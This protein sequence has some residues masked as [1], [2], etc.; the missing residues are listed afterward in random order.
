MRSRDD[1]IEDVAL[2]SLSSA[3]RPQQTMVASHDYATWLAATS[4][5]LYTTVELFEASVTASSSLSLIS[6]RE[7]FK[8]GYTAPAK[9]ATQ[10]DSKGGL[11]LLFRVRFAIAFVGE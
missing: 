2:L 8:R 6:L 1:S 10:G 4:L 9:F 5:V 11:V 3:Q 7:N